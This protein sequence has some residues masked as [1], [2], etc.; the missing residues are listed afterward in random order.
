MRS[1]RSRWHCFATDRWAV[2]TPA[3]SLRPAGSRL[4]T[5][6]IRILAG[7][8]VAGLGFAGPSAGQDP[9][10]DITCSDCHTDETLTAT[11]LAGVER[12]AYVDPEAFGR[13]VHA[14]LGCTACHSDISEVPHA[15]DLAP[16]DC[17]SCHGDVADELG[18]SIHG[19]EAVR[20]SGHAP[21]CV[22]CHG[23]AHLILPKSDPASRTHP[24]NQVGV[25]IDCHTDPQVTAAH[26]LP[27]PERIAGYREGAHGRGLLRSGLVFSASCVSCHGSH[28]VLPPT[29]EGSTVHW[30]KVPEM[31][32]E[33]HL[34][35]LRD[36][37]ESDHGVL[38][39][40]GSDRA[41][42]C[43]TCHDPHLT[44]DPV[45]EEFHQQNPETCASCHTEQEVSYRDTFHGKA[46]ELGLRAAASCA[47]CH[48]PHANHGA[49]D[50]RS[51][52]H[53]T[54]LA[55]TCGNCHEN[56]S[57]NLLGYDP[58]ARPTDK[59]RSALLYYIYLGMETLLYGV[60]GFFSL[61][62][63]LW[64]QRAV[65]AWRRGELPRYAYDEAGPWVTR[66]LLRDRILHATVMFSFVGLAFT[67]VPVNLNFTPW[68]QNLV[69]TFGGAQT[70]RYFHRL[71]A[72]VTFGYAFF[73]L[74]YL[75]R[76]VLVE[77]RY[78]LLYGPL[79]MVPRTKDL[80]DLFQQLRWFLY[81]GK[82]AKFDRWTYWEKFDYFA[83]FWGVPV[84]GIS[85]LMLWQPGWF[86]FLPG[87]ALNVAQIIHGEEARLAIGFIFLFHFFHTHMRPDA[88][89]MDLV[90]FTGKMPLA[91]FQHE[92]A[93]EY[94]RMVA[95]GTLEEH[96]VPAPTAVQ[97]RWAFAI[98]STG[99]G[100]GL[101][102][103][104]H[105]IY[106]AIFY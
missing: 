91:R 45:G 61:H 103:I 9:E 48:T 76:R 14:D 41:P 46:V 52:V 40:S 87:V 2:I 89:P 31:C 26:Q 104:L 72:I 17:A 16:V 7:L 12:S 19:G 65:V 54:N 71:F 94:Q 106:T 90:I 62:T 23:S 4:P 38:W 8:L 3:T 68:A 95:A 56:P 32:G 74:G 6:G 99:L 15:D 67:G 5:R 22:T 88:F 10:L 63:L 82:P 51:S 66:F 55:T 75:V 24:L 1:V 105:I 34:G 59:E 86:A 50:P 102:L 98:G 42:G 85:G 21:S 97:R 25:C 27:A 39:A 81:M 28:A 93:E 29:E 36:F 70:F 20:A 100:I 58:H 64:F 30:S 13:S 53:P 60:F 80:S 73:H 18:A 57:A 79:S 92:R 35:I 83:V 33:C 78:S 96:L 11:D 69:E 77:K 43:N 37:R 49:D 47:D 84:I 101:F 44:L